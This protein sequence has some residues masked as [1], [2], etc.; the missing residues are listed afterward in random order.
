VFDT[1]DEQY[2]I[3]QIATN[4]CVLFLG[5]GFCAD[6]TNRLGVRPPLGGQLGEILW[7]FLGYAPPVPKAFDLQKIFQMVLT[8]GRPDSDIQSLLND[9]LLI[10]DVPDVYDVITLPFWKRIYTTNIDNS[11]ATI[12]RRAHQQLLDIIAHPARAVPEVD[13]FLRRVQCV[14][15]HGLLPCA[16]RD[17]TFSTEQ[18]AKRAAEGLDRLYDQF[19]GDY[20]TRPVIFVGTELDEP[21]FYQYVAAREM[22]G[23]ASRENR[24]KSFIISPTLVEPAA[25]QLFG[26]F[27]VTPYKNTTKDFLDW[28]AAIK[29]RLPSREDFLAQEIPTISTL[30]ATTGTSKSKEKEIEQFSAS[31]HEVPL[32]K[33]PASTRSKYL[34]G[35]SPRWEDILNDLD[36]PREISATVVQDVEDALDS[37]EG[38]AVVALTGPAGCG[39]STVLRRVGLTLA[40]T[41]RACFLTNSESLPP[42]HV[43]TNIA[44]ESKKRLV[45][46]FD[47]AEEAL[48]S[49]TRLAEKLQK[50][51]RPPVILLAAQQN[52]FHRKFGRINLGNGKVIERSVPNLSRTEID[53]VLGKLE[54]ANLLGKLRAMTHAE[55]VRQFSIRA[56]KQILVAMREATEGQDFNTILRREYET[57][58]SDEAKI[59][60]LCVGLCSEA[61]YRIEKSDF[62]RC[63]RVKPAVALDILD[64]VLQGIVLKSGVDENLLMLR[65]RLIA[66]YIVDQAASRDFVYEA[67]KRLIP[68][69]VPASGGRTLHTRKFRLYR[70]LI[71]HQ[72]LI[73]RFEGRLDLPR[74]IYAELGRFVENDPQYYLQYGCYEMQVGDLDFARNFL[75]Q[76][77]ELEPN[78]RYIVNAMGQLYLKQAV[79][80]SNRETAAELRR[81]GLS[82]LEGNYD[83]FSGKYDAH[84]YSIVGEQQLAW[85]KKWCL[86][87][88]EKS[89][90]LEALDAFCVKGRKNFPASRE[91]EDLSE[92]VRG[93]YLRSGLGT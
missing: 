75:R 59:L 70:E 48:I 9:N 24:P 58:P 29:A 26:A 86:N 93:E 34:L 7:D 57:L 56:G 42:S 60:D 18:Y 36:A 85:I 72:V 40:R 38:V 67:Y 23:E 81:E 39:K 89:K 92:T 78:N 32:Q 66:K 49:I 41:G 83:I 91:L 74:A 43:V 6:M 15:L 73:N 61:G 1:N 90:E 79:A 27:N 2:L 30:K 19:V 4:N 21:V 5:A 3:R 28:L 54:G 10:D 65:H 35:S 44:A 13:Q 22:R 46:L 84:Y 50:L 16:P 80:A 69:I 77:D 31:F 11:L 62:V 82:L 53:S 87:G 45:L 12:Y 64:V 55:R 25:T 14:Y 52:D 37:Y 51:E 8:S 88:P 47:N 76:A 17:L 71:N 20:A 68:V 33:K 63:A